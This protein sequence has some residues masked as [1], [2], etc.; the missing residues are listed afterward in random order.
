MSS[1]DISVFELRRL[2]D[3]DK[4]TGLFTWKVSPWHHN[5]KFKKG[6]NAG[7]LNRRGYL[8]IKLIGIRYSSHRL[9][10]L[11]T[12]GRW[13]EDQ[14]DH[15]DQNKTNNKWANL[16]SCNN[17]YNHHNKPKQAN[18]KSGV[19]GVIWKQDINKWI[20]YITIKGKKTHLGSY[21]DKQEAINARLLSES[22]NGYHPNHGKQSKS[23]NKNGGKPYA[24]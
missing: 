13:P 23:D 1:K 20:S 16:V 5:C 15:D 12:L 9:A 3:Y 11:H 6:D 17:R 22:Q 24:F 8:T 10:Y 19:T 18:N 4:E 14:V 7:D 21:K 2:L